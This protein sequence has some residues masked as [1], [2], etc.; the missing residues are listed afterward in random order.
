MEP[1]EILKITTVSGC[2][3]SD[4]MIHLVILMV[5]MMDSVILVVVKGI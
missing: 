3:N 5:V 1:L 2:K 4:S